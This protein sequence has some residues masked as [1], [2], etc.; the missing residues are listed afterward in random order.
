[1]RIGRRSTNGAGSKEPGGLKPETVWLLPVVAP[2]VLAG[3]VVTALALGSLATRQASTT[4]IV[5]A[6][7]LFAAAT[8]AEAYPVPIEGVSAGGVSLAASFLV[9]AALIYDWHTAVLLSLCVRGMIEVV[10]R[11]PLMK[12]AYNS[13]VFALSG[14]AAGAAALVTGGS[15]RSI[16][17]LLVSVATASLAF[18]SVNVPL[19]AIVVARATRSKAL[20]IVH[21]SVRWTAVPFAI[22]ASISLILSV[23][24]DRSPILAAA[25]AGP[26]VAVGLYQR[27]VHGALEAMRLAKTDPLT[28]LGNHRAFQEALGTALQRAQPLA[29]CLI[30]V[31]GF[32]LIND[33]HGHQAGDHV[34]VQLA[35]HL[36]SDGE[37]FRLGGDE[38]AIVLLGASGEESREI[39][40]K[41]IDRIESLRHDWGGS[42]TVSAGLSLAPDHADEPDRLF[43]AADTALYQAKRRGRNQVQTFDPRVAVLAQARSEALRAERL[44]A[45]WGLVDL[46]DTADGLRDE[47]VYGDGHSQRVSE[48]AARLAIRCGIT[49]DQIELVRLAARLHDLGKLAVPVEILRKPGSLL[50]REWQ[51]LEEHPETGKQIL[52]AIGAGA[53]ADWVLHHHER[54]DGRGYP[55]GLVG[56][57]IPLAARIIFVA[58]A[59]DAMTSGRPY[60]KAR[61]EAEA[62]VELELYAGTQFDPGVVAALLAELAERRLDERLTA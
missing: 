52:S 39:A 17:W 12:I 49:D 6:L 13:A 10:Q 50:E 22:M 31:D 60:R 30:D 47:H 16:P 59:F 27:S 7:V 1:L 40:Q 26:L 36:R 5:G 58:D 21:Q 54:W 38:F 2:V 37:A 28:G 42:V 32:K 41:L 4:G 46:V 29:L 48:L 62:V 9:G 35:S 43:A 44:H 14:G 33:R 57:E 25:L 34:L 55:S 8:A 51:V 15:G 20:E 18:Y 3:T 45:A 24:W 56:D 19:V 53:I 11:R 23:L 61:T